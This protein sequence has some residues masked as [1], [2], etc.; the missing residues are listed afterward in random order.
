MNRLRQPILSERPEP[1]QARVQVLSLAEFLI[2]LREEEEYFPES[3]GNTN[4]LTTLLRKIFYDKWGWDTQLIRA[5]AFIKCRYQVDIVDCPTD[6][7]PPMEVKQLRRY[8]DLVNVP[9]CRLVTYRADDRKF[10]DRARKV[11]EIY[12]NNHQVVRLPEGFYC[13]LGHTLAG[14]DALNHPQ[15]VTPLPF[16]LSF[17]RK[18]LPY[19]DSNVAVCT[20]LGDI[21]TTAGDFLLATLRRNN[22]RLSIE[23]E[24]E[25][26]ERNAPGSDMLGNIDS[27]VIYKAYNLKTR[28]G[29]RVSE[30]LE[31]YYSQGNE[32][33]EQ[34]FKIFAQ[35]IGLGEFTSNTFNNEEQWLRYHKKQLRNTAAFM[36]NSVS[37]GF[38]LKYLV[39]WKLW[40]KRYE[41]VIQLEL[42]L[43]LFLDELKRL[44]TWNSK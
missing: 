23:V 28:N 1:G 2:L 16:I 6:G 35:C 39:P 12:R 17:L 40:R 5:T 21:A 13:D 20:W 42:L 31:D 29:Q 22:G 37:S 14:L 4:R 9:K 7:I 43:N 30:I 19:A 8:K 34:R 24:Q 32:F 27:Y 18:L 36:V 33:R 41:D 25:L 44:I 3:I 26:I 15:A 38:K 10:P 11:P